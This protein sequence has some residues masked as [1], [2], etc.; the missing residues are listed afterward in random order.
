ML[1]ERLAPLRDRYEYILLDCPPSLGPL[2]VSAL[3]AA[4][5]RDRAGTDRVLRAGGPGRAARDARARAARAQPAA[6]G[7][8]MLLTMHDGRT[9]LGQDVEREVREHFP[10]LVF[11]TVIP[12][13]VRVGEAPSY[14]LPV[15][16]HD[17]HSAGAEAYFELARGGGG[18]WLSRGRGMGR[19]LEAILSVSA[20]APTRRAG[21]ARAA[22][23]ADLAQP[24]PAPQALRRA[25]RSRRSPARSAS[26][27]CCSR[28]SCA[29][30]PAGA[31]S[32]SPA[33]VAGG[34]RRSRASSRSPRSC[35]PRE[36]AEALELALIENMA[37]EDLN[38]IEEARACAALV[39][40][41][42]LTRED[43]GRRVGRSRVAVSNLMRLLDLP[44]EAIELLQQGAL[45]RGARPRA[46]A[47]RGPRR[48]P[49]PRPRGGRRRGGRCVCSKS[50]R[51]R[52]T[53][54][55]E[56]TRRR[57]PATAGRGP[58]RPGAGGG[59]DRRRA[60]RPHSAP[61]CTCDPDAA[62]AITPSCRFDSV[63]GGGRAGAQAAASRGG[64]APMAD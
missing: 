33:S 64:L 56:R 28:C 2:T 13:N 39:E 62:G 54:S 1:R 31:M 32:W 37:R 36:D 9:R 60:R 29:R 21:A 43:V 50:G 35:A 46:A 20:E 61:R 52:A 24:Q 15:T 55:S 48:A 49:A 11:D 30:G 23:R 16:H 34:P 47:G 4:D 12:R 41:L 38:P 7:R 22:D 42:G 59:R 53:P 45:E 10:E 14:G 27:A 57:A 5:G 25:G 44:D 6:D 58:S 51:G 19:G 18:A 26:A 17:P 3:V 40:E 63:D 8:G